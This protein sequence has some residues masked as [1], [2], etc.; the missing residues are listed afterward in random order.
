MQAYIQFGAWG[1][2]Y[3]TVA[4]EVRDAPMWHHERGLSY[5][6]TGY[7]NKLPQPW[8]VKWNGRWRRVYCA[9]FSNLG[10]NYIVIDGVNV[11]VSLEQ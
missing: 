6:R 3:Q 8:Q 2:P 9:C 5:T 4:A 1:G 7:G 11:V 10:T